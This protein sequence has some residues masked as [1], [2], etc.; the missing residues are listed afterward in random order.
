[1]VKRPKSPEVVEEARYFTV[2]QPYP[3][4]ANWVFEEDQIECARWVAECI[5]P[6]YVWGMHEKPSARGMVLLEISKEFTDHARLLGEHRWS[7]MLKAPKDEEK[8][9][10]SQVFHSFYAKGRDAQKDG[11]KHIP[12]KASWF[13]RDWKPGERGI[14]HPYP[15]THWCNVPTEDKTNKPLCRPLPVQEK[16]PPPAVPPP[17]PVVGSSKWVDKQNKASPTRSAW[18]KGPQPLDI[19]RANQASRP[20]PKSTSQSPLTA[21]SPQLSKGEGISAVSPRSGNVNGVALAASSPST[22]QPS[23]NPVSP[24]QKTA[25]AKLIPL[26]DF[27]SK[28]GNQVPNKPWG[29]DKQPTP[30]SATES[31]FSAPSPGPRNASD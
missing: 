25:R 16:P 18:A 20:A 2:C 8:P 22:G 31:S 27:V 7:E 13:G 26:K 10:V 30:T 4:N 28:G 19:G 1:M 14:R 11:W 5:G 15:A 9:R 21:L 23:P 6:N 12:V 3:L 29:P 24:R 17:A